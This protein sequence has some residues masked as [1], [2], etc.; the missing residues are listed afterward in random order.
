MARKYKRIRAKNT[1]NPTKNIAYR[2]GSEG[3]KHDPYGY[4]EYIGYTKYAEGGVRVKLHLGLLNYLEV[5]RDQ[6]HD[7]DLGLDLNTRKGNEKAYAILT[8]RFERLVGTTIAAI[9]KYRRS[10]EPDPMGTLADY[11]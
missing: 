5:G 2:T 3:P 9:D 7:H 8:K 4:E 1:P 10:L 11:E 6:V